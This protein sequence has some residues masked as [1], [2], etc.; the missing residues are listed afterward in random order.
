MIQVDQKLQT[1]TDDLV[2]LRPFD[3][4]DKAHA[5]RVMLVLRIVQTLFRR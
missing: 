2:R 5:A 1:L 4:G 3:V